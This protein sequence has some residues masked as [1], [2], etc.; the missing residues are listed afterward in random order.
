MLW[1]KDGVH[2]GQLVSFPDETSTAQLNGELSET[3]DY[4][5]VRKKQKQNGK[6]CL[7][8]EFKNKFKKQSQ[9]ENSM[10]N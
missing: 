3:L 10:R 2:I 1:V 4:E 7:D 9:W 8:H 5:E 6:A